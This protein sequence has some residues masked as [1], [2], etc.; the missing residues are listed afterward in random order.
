MCVDDVPSAGWS[1]VV[2]VEEDDV[3]G[4]VIGVVGEVAILVVAAETSDIMVC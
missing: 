2:A 4:A 1:A 3:V